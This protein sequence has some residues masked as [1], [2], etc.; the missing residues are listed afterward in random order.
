MIP[1]QVFE[2]AKGAV[3]LRKIPH[4]FRGAIKLTVVII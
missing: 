4:L 2:P 1:G 3:D